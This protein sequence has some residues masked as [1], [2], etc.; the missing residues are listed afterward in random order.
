MNQEVRGNI[1]GDFAG[2]DI[3]NEAPAAPRIQ[4][5][6]ISGGT[7]HFI[8]GPAH[9]HMPAQVK[10]KTQVVVPTGPQHISDEQARLLQR[11]VREIV[12][13]EKRQK[14]KPKG[15]QAVWVALN[16]H[17]R[18]PQYR[19]IA[20]ESF[21]KAEKYLR[22]WIGRLNSMASAPVVD[23]DAWRKSR[24]AFIKIN[25]KDEPGA[26]WLAV[27]LQR[28]FAATSIADLDDAA[29]D[30]TYRAVASRK[31]NVARE[32]VPRRA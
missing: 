16:S 17:C 18:A 2:R 3:I 30:R 26:A 23:N 29:L 5:G 28:T 11:L 8:D 6:H 27:Y 14:Q 32:A 19:L 13:L 31:R 9:F 12:E 15:F 24:Y 25:T 7:Q 22:Q 1:A 21:E 4:I 20:A 10:I